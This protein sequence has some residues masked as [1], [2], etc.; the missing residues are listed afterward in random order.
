MRGFSTTANY[1]R[2]GGMKIVYPVSEN[3]V[4]SEFLRGEYHQPEYHR[5]REHHETFVTNPDLNDSRQNHLRRKL[6]FRRHRVTWNELPDNVAWFRTE[7]NAEDLERIRVFPR[8]HWPRMANGLSLSVNDLVSAIRTNKFHPSTVEDVNSIQ[9]IASQL[10]Q[11]SDAGSIMLIGI[12]ESSPL[13][14]LEGNHRMIAA[15]LVSPTQFA[16]FNCYCGF[17]P[18]MEKCFWYQDN[19]EN[20]VRHA[21]RRVLNNQP[22]LKASLLHLGFSPRLIKGF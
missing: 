4:I 19:R 11:R 7:L 1:G 15:A 3:E 10:R 9:A 18:K 17:S 21:I 16:N 5:D 12:D 22:R 13:T 6:L 8:G 20:F 2:E 14:I